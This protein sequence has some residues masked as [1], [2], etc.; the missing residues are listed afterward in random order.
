[1]RIS[2]GNRSSNQQTRRAVGAQPSR[3]MSAGRQLTSDATLQ[4][5]RGKS[6][7]PAPQ[8]ALEQWHEMVATAAYFRAQQRSFCGGSPEQDWLEAEAELRRSLDAK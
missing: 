7:Y 3:A 4:A 1:M 2:G 8:F 6:V 5:P